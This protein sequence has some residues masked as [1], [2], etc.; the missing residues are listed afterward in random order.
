M[1]LEQLWHHA[2]DFVICGFQRL[3]ECHDPDRWVGSVNMG[4][5]L[6]YDLPRRI[7]LDVQKLLAWI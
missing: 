7:G 4:W 1:L 5:E 3:V 2:G 6:K